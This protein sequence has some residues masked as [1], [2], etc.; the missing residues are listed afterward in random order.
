[1][2]LQK[3]IAIFLTVISTLASAQIYKTT[4]EKGNPQFTDKP[5]P[6]ATNATKVH[7]EPVNTVTPIETRPEAPVTADNEASTIYQTLAITSP[8]NE[9][10]IP[11]GLSATKVTA[12]IS[13][14]LLKGHQL[15][16]LV[17]GI[18][19]GTGTSSSF[20]VPTLDR[21]TNTLQLEVLAASG[22]IQSSAI[23]TIFVYRP[24]GK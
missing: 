12:A 4:D 24:G 20:V 22:S 9:S 10:I 15:R 21:G 11:N 19:A 1:M 13:P 2:T 18:E 14:T 7:L 3:L 8:D 23:V 16:L 5:E 17:N 6:G